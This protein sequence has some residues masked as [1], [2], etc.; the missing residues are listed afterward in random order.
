LQE[1]TLIN[2]KTR[3]ATTEALGVMRSL[4]IPD[5]G[6]A[7][8]DCDQPAVLFWRAFVAAGGLDLSPKIWHLE[9]GAMEGVALAIEQALVTG[10]D[11]SKAVARFMYLTPDRHDW[12]KVDSGYEVAPCYCLDE[13][14]G[15]LFVR[16]I[17]RSYLA[18]QVLQGVALLKELDRL[19]KLTKKRPSV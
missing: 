19:D 16:E 14:L 4:Q 11:A 7:Q 13:A 10:V 12:L 3:Q 18:I 8:W 17:N 15:D 1:T 2:P 9:R 6:F 5:M